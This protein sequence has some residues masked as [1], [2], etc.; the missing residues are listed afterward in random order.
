MTPKL[1]S[2]SA[3]AHGLADVVAIGDE[4][5]GGEPDGARA[6]SGAGGELEEFAA[7]LAAA[8]ASAAL[9]DFQSGSPLVMRAPAP[10][11]ASAR[12]RS[13]LRHVAAEGQRDQ[14]ARIAAEHERR[15]GGIIANLHRHDSPGCNAAS[16][17]AQSAASPFDIRECPLDLAVGRQHGRGPPRAGQRFRPPGENRIIFVARVHRNE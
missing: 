12:S 3:D 1:I 5:R 13:S 7:R 15:P 10:Q 6:G 17:S 11:V 8:S 4:L 16:F 2:A 9:L 14:P